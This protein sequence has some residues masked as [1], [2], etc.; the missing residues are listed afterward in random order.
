MPMMLSDFGVDEVHAQGLEGCNRA[1]L[2]NPD[3]PRVADH[4]SGQD[5]CELTLHAWSPWPGRLAAGRPKIHLLEKGRNVAFWLQADIQS[6]EIEVRFTPSRRHSRA[7]AAKP[8]HHC[9]A[10]WRGQARGIGRTPR[11]RGRE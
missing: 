7:A 5:S 9:R 2:I 8:A 1:L 4:I 6:L 10:P 3:Q 11:G